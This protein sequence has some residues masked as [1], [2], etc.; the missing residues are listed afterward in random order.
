MRRI[1]SPES[2]AASI[3]G[4]MKS[5]AKTKSSQANGLKGGKPKNLNGGRPKGSKNKKQVKK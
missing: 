1:H 4:A 3:L 5:P 2:I